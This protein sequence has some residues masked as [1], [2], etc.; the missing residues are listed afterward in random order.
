VS[1]RVGQRRLNDL[2]LFAAREL[3][4]HKLTGDSIQ[5]RSTLDSQPQQRI[6]GIG[7]RNRCNKHRNQQTKRPNAPYRMA[8]SALWN[9]VLVS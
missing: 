9:Q 5:G 8:L 4:A 2:E 6:F 1:I 3:L 7:A